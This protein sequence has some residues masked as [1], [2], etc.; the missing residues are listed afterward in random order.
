VRRRLI[1]TYGKT[2]LPPIPKRHDFCIREV[3]L[4][5]L[6]R[7]LRLLDL[8]VRSP[9]LS[10]GQDNLCLSASDLLSGGLQGGIV[11]ASSLTRVIHVLG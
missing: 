3:K 7:F 1:S 8:S 2:K 6:D 10:V 4:S 5:L 9:D 11:A